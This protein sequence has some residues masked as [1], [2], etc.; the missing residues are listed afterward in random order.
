MEARRRDYHYC[1]SDKEMLS[2]EF[3]IHLPS[4]IPEFL[5]RRIRDGTASTVPSEI[6][7]WV[8]IAAKLRANK[9]RKF[10]SRGG[11]AVMAHVSVLKYY[12]FLVGWIKVYD[13]DHD[14][15]L[16]GSLYPKQ[17]THASIGRLEGCALQY[18]CILQDHLRV[19]RGI[20]MRNLASIEWGRRSGEAIERLHGMK[21]RLEDF[22][23]S[24]PPNSSRDKIIREQASDSIT[25]QVAIP[26]C[27]GIWR[28]FKEHVSIQTS[29][30]IKRSITIVRPTQ[31]GAAMNNAAPKATSEHDPGRIP[32]PPRRK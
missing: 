17:Y 20:L 18:I 4:F 7:E 25:Y 10:A 14:P 3:F 5:Y 29:A 15:H 23:R 31:K 12:S 11:E 8:E 22:V 30:P 1:L 2:I 28:E 19:V 32:V 21:L 6:R 24:T 27:E 26:A 16:P 9:D 13:V